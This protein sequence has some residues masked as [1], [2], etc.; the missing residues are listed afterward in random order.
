M[1]L[2]RVDLPLDGLDVR[3]QTV[4]FELS[5]VFDYLRV[6]I[7]LHIHLLKVAGRQKSIFLIYNVSKHRSALLSIIDL[8]IHIVFQF[9]YL[10]QD[11]ILKH[12]IGIR[13]LR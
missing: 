2:E 4:K 5:V 8:P 13:V 7:F 12:I 1:L 10:S 3:N 6:H 11:L 9:L